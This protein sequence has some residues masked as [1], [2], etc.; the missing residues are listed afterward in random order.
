MEIET[1]NLSDWSLRN[2]ADEPRLSEL[3][4]LYEE[5]GFEVKLEEIKIGEIDYA[6]PCN[7]CFNDKNNKSKIIYTRK[8]KSDDR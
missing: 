2:I 3:V 7:T 5:L 8:P 6:S 1:N 4:F